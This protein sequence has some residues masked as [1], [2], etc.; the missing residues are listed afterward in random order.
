MGN[1]TCLLLLAANSSP[2]FTWT[3]SSW[4]GVATLTQTALPDDA[5]SLHCEVSGKKAWV[6]EACLVRKTDFIFVSDDCGAVVTLNEYP[7][8]ADKTEL[9]PLAA[10]LTV[11]GNPPEFSHRVIRLGEFVDASG[12]P[13]EGRR[14]RWLAG[15]VGEPGTRPHVSA[16]GTAIEFSTLDGTSR[17]V[18]FK[19]PEDFLPKVAAAPAQAELMYQ[20][21]GDD[22]ATQFVF[23]LNQ[24]P[25]KFRKRARL[26]ESEI[27]SVEAAPMPNR[28]LPVVTRIERTQG[29]PRPPPMTPP[30]VVKASPEAAECKIF[31]LPGPACNA[32]QL[33]QARRWRRTHHSLPPLPPP[34]PP[35]SPYQTPP[36]PYR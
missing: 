13:G 20:F 10:T 25:A 8:R 9:T 15:V 23:G 7:L 35:A 19:N 28:P 11:K 26:V 6:R 2:E 31:G 36:S 17:S 22:G 16:D 34:K 33:E 29:E 30:V 5:C 4:R 14:V 24:V 32:V 12:L 21:T 27:G 18:R 3:V 1:L